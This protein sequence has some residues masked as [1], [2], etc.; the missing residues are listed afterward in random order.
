MSSSGAARGSACVSAP[1]SA[2]AA[3]RHGEASAAGAV[4]DFESDGRT[5]FR[6][7][8]RLGRGHTSMLMLFGVQRLRHCVV[9]GEWALPLET[10]DDPNWS[11][12]CQKPGLK[13]HTTR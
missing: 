2:S 6:P 13:M 12:I 7:R 1:G 11:G 5:G 3:G 10:A 8:S 4:K 9:A